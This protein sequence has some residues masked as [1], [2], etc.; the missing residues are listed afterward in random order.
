MVIAIARRRAAA[1]FRFDALSDFVVAV[2]SHGH[3]F[4]CGF[5]ELIRGVVAVG[6]FG[7]DG[8]GVVGFVVFVFGGGAFGEAVVGVVGVRGFFFSG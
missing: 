8:C 1:W 5:F 3:F 6:V 4:E 7:A 2:A